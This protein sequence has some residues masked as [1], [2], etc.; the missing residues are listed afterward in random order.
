MIQRIQS[1]YLL[2]T[3]LLSVLF[4]SGNIIVFHNSD[5]LFLRIIIS[6]IYLTAGGVESEIGPSSLL[7]VPAI[8]TGLMSLTAIFM[9]K[10]R[11]VQLWLVRMA[12]TFIIMAILGGAYYSLMLIKKYEIV[13]EM[14]FRIFL[15]LLIIVLIILA[16]R[17][18]IRDEKLVR[19]Y[20]RLR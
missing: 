6:G 5:G 8:L 3:T 15:P 11:V 1:V 4:L 10:R 16:L 14:G 13:L 20:D 19:S 2:L 7:V 9:F 17:G 12:M 18:I